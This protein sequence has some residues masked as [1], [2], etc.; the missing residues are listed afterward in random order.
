[1]ISR[2]ELTQKP[3]AKTLVIAV[4][5]VSIAG[6][7]LFQSYRMETTITIGVVSLFL[8]LVWDLRLLLPIVLVVGPLGPKF[9]LSFG[10]FYLTTGI[11]FIAYAAWLWRSSLVRSGLALIRNPVSDAILIMFASMLCSFMNAPGLVLSAGEH[12]L[13]VIQFIMYTGIFLLALPMKFSRSEIKA[14]ILLALLVAF[15]EALIGS[16]QWVTNPGFYVVG[17]FDFIHNNFAAYMTFM[18]FLFLGIVLEADSPKIVLLAFVALAFSLYSLTFAFS[19]SAYVAFAVGLVVTLFLPFK[20][21]RRILLLIASI[22]GV[23]LFIK[24]VPR[25]VIA[26][27]M[28]I[29]DVGAGIH[30]D[31]S[32]AARL[33]LWRRALSN[34]SQSP[35]FG[36]GI[37]TYGLADNFYMKTL[38]ETGIAGLIALILVIRALLRQ[39]W[40]IVQ[41]R[42]ADSLIR[43]IAKAFIPGTVAAIIVMNASG[44]QLM[45]HRFMGVYWILLSLLMKWS[46]KELNECPRSVKSS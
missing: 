37:G 16:Y 7:I 44:D 26:R 5:C 4:A 2:Y 13:R 45:V 33:G 15:V 9:P 10:N 46:A 27:A 36:N 3:T 20:A 41:S 32:F 35:I 39:Q 14:L 42:I 1:M 11:L 40:R 38:A 34:F 25:E 43:S 31:I 22:I 8:L 21:R 6:T 18:V 30:R 17:T 19:R 29:M 23:I 24:F 28:S 12:A